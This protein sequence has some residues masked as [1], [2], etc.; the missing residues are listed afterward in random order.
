[1]IRTLYLDIETS[2]TN[3]LSFGI[4]KQYLTDNQIVEPSHIC[5]FTAKWKGK[6]NK[7]IFYS[8]PNNNVVTERRMLVALR[9]LLD[10]ADLVIHY[11]GKSFDNKVIRWHLMKNKIAPPSPYQQLDLYNIMKTTKPESRKLDYIS[12]EFGI[13]NKLEH[14]GFDLWKKC[15]NGDKQA[16]AKMKAYNI[17]DVKLLERLHNY[18]ADW[19]PPLIFDDVDQCTHPGLKAYGYYRTKQTIY[20]RNYCPDCKHYIRGAKISGTKHPVIPV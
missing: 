10:E 16:W 17:Q 12:R 5:C 18:I 9:N 2:L 19:I 4:R 13:G 8:N 6:N 3:V 14:E 11:N 1:M 7:P 20:Q 15:W